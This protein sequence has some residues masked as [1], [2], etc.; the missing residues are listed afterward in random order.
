MRRIFGDRLRELFGLSQV[1]KSSLWVWEGGGGGRG[2][3][4]LILFMYV[5]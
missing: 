5:N 3:I 4:F 2:G 1:C